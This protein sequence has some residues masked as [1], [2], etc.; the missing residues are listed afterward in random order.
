MCSA[1]AHSK[2][3]SMSTEKERCSEPSPAPCARASWGLQTRSE[4]REGCDLQPPFPPVFPPRPLCKP[5]YKR[6]RVTNA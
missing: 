2:G 4:A 5:S 3:G 6:D 1:P